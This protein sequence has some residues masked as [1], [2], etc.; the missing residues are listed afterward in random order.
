MPPHCETLSAPV[1]PA[2]NPQPCHLPQ[3]SPDHTTSRSRPPQTPHTSCSIA[4]ATRATRIETHCPL[5]LIAIATVKQFTGLGRDLLV[6]WHTLARRISEISRTTLKHNRSGSSQR[7]RTTQP[8]L[9]QSR[10][11]KTACS[12]LVQ[13]RRI[14]ADG[15]DRSAVVPTD[16]RRRGL[17]LSQFRGQMP[18]SG[19][20]NWD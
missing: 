15:L 13:P 11:T 14:P 19:H 10:D 16:N 1:A 7:R 3:Q 8:K 20:L 6:T 9:S 2:F 18:S 12:L 5:A 17:Q 4:K